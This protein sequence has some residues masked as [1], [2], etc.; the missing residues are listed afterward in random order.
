MQMP[1]FLR[2]LKIVNTKEPLGR[3]NQ[4]ALFKANGTLCS[5]YVRFMVVRVLH[6]PAGPLWLT[7]GYLKMDYGLIPAETELCIL[8]KFPPH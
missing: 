6:R 8:E 4:E 1:L 5:H 2:G 7:M 3:N